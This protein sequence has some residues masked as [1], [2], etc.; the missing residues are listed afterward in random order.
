MTKMC[1]L[2]SLWVCAIIASD[3]YG[4][5]HIKHLCIGMDG[6]R[7]WARSRGLPDYVGHREGSKCV[8]GIMQYCLDRGISYLSLY[9]FSLENLV[10]RPQEEKTH[11]FDL[12]STF[13]RH[14]LPFFLQHGIRIRVIGDRELV[15]LSVR[16]ACSEVER[17]TEQQQM[18]VVNFLFCYGGQQ[19]IVA[20]TRTCVE[21]VM[22]GDDDLK[23]LDVPM[24]AQLLWSGDIPA[25]EL[26]IRTGGVKR[27][28][29]GMLFHAAYS[30]LFFVDT[31]WPDFT[32][33]ELDQLVTHYE[34]ITKNFGR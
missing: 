13:L 1:A 18:L 14:K 16:E 3:C 33:Q 6:N 27:L 21:R 28:S 4:H 32:V 9:V 31:L 2:L 30:E 15:P 29:N 10:K 8:D 19:E 5:S 22:C 24:F 17:A 23:K 26:M 12:F 7:R 11:L 20:A 25:P 34:L